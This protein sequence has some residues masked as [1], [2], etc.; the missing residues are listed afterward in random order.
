VSNK[1]YRGDVDRLKVCVI[2]AG[3]SGLITI[4]EL[5]DENHA[6]VCYEKQSAEGGIFNVDDRVGNTA[7][8]STLLT[9]SNYAMAFSCFPPKE[10]EERRFWT[11]KEYQRYLARFADHYQL[12]DYITF[13]SEVLSIERFKDSLW[14]VK[15]RVGGEEREE[16]FDAVAVCSGAFQQAKYPDLPFVGGDR[17]GVEV[18]HS[19]DYRRPEPYMGKRVLCIGMAESGADIVHEI[20]QVADAATLSVRP[21]P[22]PLIPRYDCEH[23]GAIP[24]DGETTQHRY[25]AFMNQ[26]RSRFNRTRDVSAWHEAR[27]AELAELDTEL[28]AD[29]AAHLDDRYARIEALISDWN[30][31]SFAGGLPFV[32]RFLNKNT[33]FVSDIADGRLR[34]N[35]S[36]IER[37]EGQTVVFKD[38]RTFEVDTI[39]CCTG[40]QE[41]HC[42]FFQSDPLLRKHLGGT[43]N[44]REWFRHS[45]HPKVGKSIGF[46]GWARPSQG[47]LPPLSELQARYFALLCSNRRKLPANLE[48]VTR[49]E[50]AA[51]LDMLKGDP[52]ILTLV[53]Y[54]YYSDAMAE[55]I[56]CKPSLV[57]HLKNPYL[58]YK[59]FFGSKLSYRFRLDGP[60]R[61]PKMAGHVLKKL[62]VA[63][64]L[65]GQL[66]TGLLNVRPVYEAWALASNV[67]DGLRRRL[68]PDAPAADKAFHAWGPGQL[69][70]VAPSGQPAPAPSEEGVRVGIEVSEA[71][72][73]Q[74][75]PREQKARNGHTPA[76]ASQ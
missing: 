25:G 63:D 13:D 24:N 70:Q 33:I 10:H 30:R 26:L 45:I 65:R 67:A 8:D 29:T 51:E 61:D 47:M 58:G 48:E 5:L 11:V 12:R 75:R 50:N 59:L 76:P 60:H 49:A 35:F 56:G 4:K 27:N 32:S 57:T 31:R 46:I 53:Q 39:M 52:N 43:L 66:K 18:V 22:P 74:E 73:R 23:I 71:P 20:A 2:G 42:P 69:R 3:M 17:G 1:R 19:I 68:R 28:S 21:S 38:G 62:K 15:A 64:T 34:V 54:P 6:V 16:I 7:Y 55:L 36:G 9:I 14:R 72:L 40:Y 44:P 37:I 41:E